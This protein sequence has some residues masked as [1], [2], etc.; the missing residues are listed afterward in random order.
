[1]SA[2]RRHLCVRRLVHLLLAKTDPLGHRVRGAV[3][4]GQEEFDSIKGIFDLIQSI[5]L[6]PFNRIDSIA[7]NH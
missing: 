5:Q 6:S 3:R 1:M 2:M 4:K 7:S